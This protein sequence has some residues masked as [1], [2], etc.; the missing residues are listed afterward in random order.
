MANS[1]C[2]FYKTN[3]TYGFYWQGGGNFDNPNQIIINLANIGLFLRKHYSLKVNSNKIW[4][5]DYTYG[6]AYLKMADF[7]NA[8]LSFVKVLMSSAPLVFKLKS[9][10]WRCCMLFMRFNSHRPE[11]VT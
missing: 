10:Y 1:S 4:W 6:R 5:I 8:K 9:I 7:K 11:S 2:K 3:G